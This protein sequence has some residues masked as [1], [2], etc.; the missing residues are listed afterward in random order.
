M[1]GKVKGSEYDKEFRSLFHQYT[2]CAQSIVGFNL[3]QFT[4]KYNLNHCQSAKLRIIEGR[5]GY[6][7]EETD[8]NIIQRVHDVTQKFITA[9]DV[10]AMN[11]DQVDDVDPPIRELHQALLNY[12]G[13]PSEFT[14]LKTVQNWVSILG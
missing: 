1:S 5:S 14:G 2:L 10:V 13:L 8:R 4:N 3:E 11:S 6:K 9:M 7:G 12:P